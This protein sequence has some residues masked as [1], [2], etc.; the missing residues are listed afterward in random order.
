MESDKI[1]LTS[2]GRLC[3]NTTSHLSFVK[4]DNGIM[5]LPLGDEQRGEGLK[6]M[7]IDGSKYRKIDVKEDQEWPEIK[8]EN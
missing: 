8:I 6:L 7:V 2:N 1:W 3:V 5:L 4:L